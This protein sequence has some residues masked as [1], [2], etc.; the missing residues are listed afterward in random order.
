MAA[1][2]TSV[3]F[4]VTEPLG[5][6][7]PAPARRMIKLAEAVASHCDVTLA[8]PDGSVFPVGPFRTR[9]TGAAGNP[10]MARA[11][12][13]HDVAVV[14]TLP[15]PRQLLVARRHAPHLVVDMIAPLALE[16]AE[17]GSDTPTRAAMTRWRIR[18]QIAHMGLA[19][20]VVCTNER[21]RDLA[22]GMA[23]AG[24]ALG[25]DP[26]RRPLAERIS[27]VPQGIGA[28]PPRRGRRPLYA[29]G[30]VADTDRIAIWAGGLWS[31]FDPLTALRAFERLR[32]ERPDLKLAFVGFAHPDEQQRTAHGSL[33]D[34]VRRYV[35]DRGLEDGVVLRPAW[36]DEEDYF[37]H[38]FEADVGTSLHRPTLE[39]RFAA[40]AR[41]VDY[42]AAGLPVICTGGDTMAGV[43]ASRELGAVVAP[44]DVESCAAALDRFT[45]DPSRLER[46]TALEAFGWHSVARPLAEFCADPGPPRPP[47]P[48][49]AFVHVARHYP[50]FAATIYR[51][52]PR[53]LARAVGRRATTGIRRRSA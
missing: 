19:D 37:D 15:S 50:A 21:Q 9:E 23:F 14:P 10:D 49:D 38:L 5:P 28:V 20:L 44:L 47:R 52:S 6:S 51:T 42:V 34:E 1:R 32:P 24:A 30:A 18:E 36:L 40:R 7:P 46:S 35:R 39:A 31:W 45:R 33:A 4:V 3:V 2:R 27:V 43:V 17:I 8:A 13:G 12:A 53:D 29:S 16:A 11:I 22:L 48:R 41:I 25:R 26:S